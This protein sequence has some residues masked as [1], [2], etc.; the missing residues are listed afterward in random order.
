MIDP[1]T[2]PTD[3]GRSI[4][5]AVGIDLSQGSI[6]KVM[7]P[8]RLGIPFGAPFPTAVFEISDQFLFLGIDR[9]HRLSASLKILHSIGMTRSLLGFLIS[10]KA[11][12]QFIQ[13][14]C[15]GYLWTVPKNSAPDRVTIT[16]VNSPPVADAGPDQTARVGNRIQL[17]GSASSDVDG[18]PLSYRWS[19]TSVPSGSG[20]AL[21]DPAA[22]KPTIDIDL[23]GTYVAELIVND[24]VH[25]SVPDLVMVT[26]QNTPPVAH[27]RADQ[28]VLV[29]DT[30]NLDGGGSSDA[31]RDPLTHRW[32]LISVPSGSEAALSDP[33]V[34]AP[35]FVVDRPGI[36][37][38]QLIVNDGS[39]DSAPDTVVI[40]TANSCPVA[41][42][43]A[44]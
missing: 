30:V 20:A 1:D 14:S 15:T 18:D 23:P 16:T 41:D 13:Q 11:I 4:I 12:S 33:G 44:D 26:T 27:A 17:D 43:G 28:T 22:V 21:P 39:D 37:V 24:A 34:A 38:A 8:N 32:S 2:D 6:N 10:L 36:Y 42:G 7:D 9:N 25:D 31:D 40:S 19:L 35:T 29:G 3:I 5:D